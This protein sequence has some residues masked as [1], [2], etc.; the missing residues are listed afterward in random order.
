ME[1]GNSTLWRKLGLIASISLF[2]ADAQIKMI[3]AVYKQNSME[4]KRSIHFSPG[5]KA[6]AGF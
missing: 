5:E 2:W 6:F 3:E 4:G 1:S